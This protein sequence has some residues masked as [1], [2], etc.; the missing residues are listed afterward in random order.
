MGPETYPISIVEQFERNVALFPDSIALECEGVTITYHALNQW[1][2]T[3]AAEL[4]RFDDAGKETV[5]A[6]WLNRSEWTCVCMLATWKAGMVYL[7]LSPENPAARNMEILRMAEPRILLYAGDGHAEPDFLEGLEEFRGLA[8][9]EIIE[10]AEIHANPGIYPAP[11]D[12]AYLM[13]TSGSTGKPKGV[14]IEHAGM[15]NHLHAKRMDFEIGEDAVVAQNASQS[16]DISVWQF[17]AAIL[18][19]GKTVVYP[20]SLVLNPLQFL[21]ALHRDEV[22]VLELVPS[23]FSLLIKYMLAAPGRFRFPALKYLVL[24]AETLPMA[25]VEKWL[26]LCPE[27]PIV[28]TYGATEAS[29]DVGHYVMRSLPGYESVPVAKGAIVNHSIFVLDA[30]G[31]RCNPGSIGEVYIAGIGV[32]RGYLKDEAATQAAF[33]MNPWSAAPERMYRTGDLGRLWEDGTLEFCGRQDR[34][35]KID[36][37]RVE[38]DEVERSIAGHPEVIHAVVVCSESEGRNPRLKGFWIARDPVG[39]EEMRK[40]LWEILPSYMV[41]S[42]LEELLEFP[43]NAN[44][45]IDL[46]ALRGRG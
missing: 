6:L 29:D 27:I 12:L 42:V 23:Y 16:F 11:G 5:V 7:P 37:Q 13:F 21:E 44:E 38:I 45:K 32:G 3:L 26:H 25:L 15:L 41:P 31:K 17:L 24:N 4:L 39:A 36:G 34:Q 33:G 1:V 14:M 9:Q 19:G 40:F 10:S 8:F 2:N 46:L 35:V 20:R 18:S 28:N 43:I 30:D 22:T